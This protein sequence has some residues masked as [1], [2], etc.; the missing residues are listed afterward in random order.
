MRER[1]QQLRAFYH[2]RKLALE[3]FSY[4]LI[5]MYRYTNIKIIYYNMH[6]HLVQTTYVLAVADH[7]N[8]IEMS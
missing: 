1:N 4:A 3:K 7:H 5:P 6:S 8:A 2:I